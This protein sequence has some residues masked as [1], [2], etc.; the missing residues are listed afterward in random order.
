MVKYDFWKSIPSLNNAYYGKNPRRP[1]RS[2][3]ENQWQQ[4]WLSVSREALH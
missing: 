3:R 1:G 2:D 4:E